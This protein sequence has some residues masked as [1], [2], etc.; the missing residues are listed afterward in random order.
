MILPTKHINE[1]RSLLGQGG[2]ILTLLHEREHTVS[3][4]WGAFLDSAGEYFEVTFD[5][6]VLALDL[7]YAIGAIKIDRGVIKIKGRP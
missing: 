6:F 7:L 4:L 2:L 1:R 3:S 5:W